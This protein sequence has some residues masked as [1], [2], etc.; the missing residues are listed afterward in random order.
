MA[1][2]RNWPCWVTICNKEDLMSWDLVFMDKE[3]IKDECLCTETSNCMAIVD[4]LNNK[5]YLIAET[6]INGKDRKAK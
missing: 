5:K 2:K 4:L 1:W 3:K 6:L